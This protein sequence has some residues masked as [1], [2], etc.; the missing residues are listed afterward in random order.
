[1]TAPPPRSRGVIALLEANC[2]VCML[3]A[4]ECPDWCIH[5]ASHTEVDDSGGGRPRQ[6][7]VL[8]RFAIDYGQCLYCGI[9]IEVCPFDAL[10][11][12]SEFGYPGTGNPSGDGAVAELVHERDR[13]GGWVV[14][15]PPPP[16]L[17]EAAEPA[18]EVGGGRPGRA[19][20]HGSGTWRRPGAFP[21]G[22][23]RAGG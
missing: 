2:T 4:R 14:D 20:G 22:E 1:M 12:A 7:N 6:R 16:E 8:D 11:W 19:A 5:I 23:R 18:P 13:L 10:H 3:C 17:D 15:V 9:C 21:D